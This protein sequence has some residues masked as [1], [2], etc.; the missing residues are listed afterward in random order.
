[1]KHTAVG[2]VDFLDSGIGGLSILDY[3]ININETEF[4][5]YEEYKTENPVPPAPEDEF[6][7]LA[8]QF[9]PEERQDSKFQILTKE[10]TGNVLYGMEEVLPL[11]LFYK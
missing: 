5:T 9:Y 10:S 1:M 8:W 11:Y 3:F 4:M 7:A 2:S 6:G